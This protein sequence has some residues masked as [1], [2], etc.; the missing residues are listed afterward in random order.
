MFTFPI[1]LTSA[2]TASLISYNMYLRSTNPFLHLG[3]CTSLFFSGKIIAT[4]L[5]KKLCPLNGTKREICILVAENSQ[6]SL[7]ITKFGWP[8]VFPGEIIRPWVNWIGVAM[9]ICYAIWLI[10]I[11]AVDFFESSPMK[12]WN[13]IIGPCDTNYEIKNERSKRYPLDRI[14]IL[15]RA[16]LGD[17]IWSVQITPKPIPIVGCVMD[18]CTNLRIKMMFS[19]SWQRFSRKFT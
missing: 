5:N 18:T 4:I 9:I 14:D 17:K 13:N 16:I 6:L 3:I 1:G 8:Q 19:Q 15:D 7:Y 10:K 11:I 12:S 2:A